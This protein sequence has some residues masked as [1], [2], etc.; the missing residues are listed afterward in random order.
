[1]LGLFSHWVWLAYLAKADL[2]WFGGMGII[3]QKGRDRKEP[4]LRVM[5]LTKLSESQ[6][7]EKEVVP[8]GDAEKESVRVFS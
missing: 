8:T 5:L 2:K 7:L 6:R 3:G 4:I 1:M